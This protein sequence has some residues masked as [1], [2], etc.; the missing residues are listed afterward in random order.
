[1]VIVSSELRTI[2]VAFHPGSS[3]PTSIALMSEIKRASPSKG[4]ISLSANAASQAL[5][6]ALAGASVISVLTEPTWFKGTLLDLRLARQA[7]DALPTRP[8]F[9]RKDFILDEYQID[10]ARLYGADTI[11]LIVAMLSPERLKALYDYSTKVRGME[12]LVEVNNAEEMRRALELGA[13]V[14]GVN[15]RNLHDFNVDMGTT[16]RL[17]DIVVE[18]NRES[19][20][21][22]ILCALSGIS[23]REDVEVYRGQGVGAVLVG[24][25]LMRASKGQTEAFIKNLLGWE[26]P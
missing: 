25:A 1:M 13:R 18:H 11:L 21:E 12:P 22:T 16:S 20:R 6:Y 15:N 3:S 17:A 7:V 14:I 4:D 9:L 5:T 2:D 10:E 26:L 23:A 24:E 8:A 19:E